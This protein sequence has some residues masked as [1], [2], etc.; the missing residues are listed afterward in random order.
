MK[1]RRYRTSCTNISFNFK[2][3]AL[4]FGI[5]AFEAGLGIESIATSRNPQLEET[6]SSRMDALP[7][8]LEIIASAQNP[9]GRCNSEDL[10]YANRWLS[11]FYQRTG[12]YVALLAIEMVDIQDREIGKK[13]DRNAVSACVDGNAKLIYDIFILNFTFYFQRDNDR[14]GY[15]L[16]RALN[17]SN[18]REGVRKR[19]KGENAE[20]A[21]VDRKAREDI[22]I[23]EAALSGAIGNY[24]DA[25]EFSNWVLTQHRRR[26]QE[27]PECYKNF[28]MISMQRY[29][30]RM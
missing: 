10:E 3:A 13:K 18:K 20:L 17:F 1:R 27:Q 7:Y 24:K 21:D 5:D 6:G 16:D 14:A 22:I 4:S 11:D 29:W 9:Q 2:K 23:S 15:F 25:Y 12:S 26:R 19:A 30:L 8:V 28:L